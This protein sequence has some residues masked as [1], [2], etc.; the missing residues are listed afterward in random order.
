[1]SD[2]LYITATE[3]RSGKSVVSL[4]LMEMLLR[5]IKRVGYFRPLVKAG[6]EPG[7][8][9]HRIQLISSRFGLDIP[10]GKMYGFTTQEARRVVAESGEGLF[11]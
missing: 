4:G 5:K 1:M 6:D 10:Y 11:L 9:D 7:K 3:S 2:S 8:R